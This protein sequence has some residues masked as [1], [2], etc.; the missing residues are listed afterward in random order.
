VEG[1][2]GNDV[3]KSKKL[4]KGGKR[5]V[6]RLRQVFADKSSYQQCRSPGEKFD[7]IEPILRRYSVKSILDVGCNAGYITRLAGQAGLFSVGI[8]IHV[9]VLRVK[10]PLERACL[11]E[12]ELNRPLVKRIPKFDAILL[13]S[14]VHQLIAFDGEKVAR[15]LVR[16]LARKARSVFLIE[17]AALNRKYGFRDSKAFDDNDEGSVIQYAQHWLR[18]SLDNWNV[19]YVGKCPETKQEPYR[20]LFACLPPLTTGRQ[21]KDL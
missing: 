8:D 18:S 10:A 19:K 21:R 17:F 6:K 13:L 20:Y 1:L 7:L 4:V 9:D 2:D 11:G 15:R 3:K 12:F 14:V 16:A 5:L